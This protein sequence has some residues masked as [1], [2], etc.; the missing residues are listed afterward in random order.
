MHDASSEIELALH[1][2][3]ISAY[4][5]GPRQ[6]VLSRQ[7]SPVMPDAGNSF[8]ICRL[9]TDWYI[10]TWAPYYYHVPS[11]ASILDLA[12]AFVNTGRSAQVRVPGELV[13]RFGLIETASAEFGRL[14]ETAGG[15]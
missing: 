6:L 8:W 3:G 7:R 1:D 2:R 5:Q 10:C 11:A 9:G 4:R 12:E 13:A 15:E 14:W